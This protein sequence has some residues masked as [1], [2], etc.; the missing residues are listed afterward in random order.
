MSRTPRWGVPHAQGA[1]VPQFKTI[2]LIQETR[3]GGGN[4][5]TKSVIV[6]NLGLLRCKFQKM[7]CSG[8]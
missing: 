8:I 5:I 2:T 7:V 3:R 1:R 4:V 6:L